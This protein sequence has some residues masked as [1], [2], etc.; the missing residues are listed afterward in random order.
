MQLSKTNIHIIGGTGQMGSWLKKFLESQGL[1]V[2]VSD[3]ETK[4]DKLIE[5]A[6][7][8]FISVP[9]NAATNIISETAKKIKKG[10]LL[11]D[12]SS[13]KEDTTK[14]LQKTTSPAISIHFLFGPTVST[15]Q[16]QKIALIKVKEN[17]LSKD[18]IKM[19]KKAGGQILEMSAE[20][21][22]QKM[23]HIQALT[24]FVNMSLA[25]VLIQDKIS[26]SGEIS[27]PVF[28]SQMSATSR[29]ISQN[30]G[31]ISQIQTRSKYFPQIVKKL[32]T[33]Q[34]ELIDLIDE[35]NEKKLENIYKEIS[36]GLDSFQ[37]DSKV[38][39]ISEQKLKTLK[40][41]EKLSL[42]FLGPEGTFSHQVATQVITDKAFLKPSKTIY[43]IFNFVGNGKADFGIVPAENSIEGTVRE[44]LDYLVD[45][46]LKVNLEISLEVHQNLLSK[47]KTLDKITRVIS[48][49]QAIAQSRGWIE[50]N[51]PKAQIEFSQSTIA[52]INETESKGVAIIGSSLAAGIYGLNIL[53]KNI[54]SKDLNIT[55]FYIVSKNLFSLKKK[56]NKTLLFLTVFNRVGILR[57]ILNVF[58]DFDINLNKLESR[59]SK[60]KNWDY[61]F[62]VELESGVSEPRLNQALNILRQFCPRI[63]VLGEY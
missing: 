30:P 58:A 48:H 37:P 35:K 36:E 12:L 63:E 44:T 24:H 61:Y 26:L 22:D 46:N 60:E 49:P 56:P 53:A 11:V 57:D 5:S 29:V 2:T 17:D 20:D 34:S 1:S 38:E 21:H 4:A 59:P 9:I 7:I 45:F 55:K 25:K 50:K 42:A 3:R 28:L 54:E 19:F 15:I 14:E 8:V 39:H 23:A 27:T 62:Y 47:E 10:A 33:I 43:D 16:N 40:I 31:L 41:K 32:Q 13:T 6:D 18:V 52:A 51:L